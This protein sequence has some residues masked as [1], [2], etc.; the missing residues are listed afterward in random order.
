MNDISIGRPTADGKPMGRRERKKM[1]TRRRIFRAAFDLFTR[2]GF[3][4]TT[5]EEIAQR[6][7]VGKGTVFNYFPQKTAF[8][9]AAYREWVELMQEELGPIDEW[10]GPTRD[11]LSRIFGYL[12]K[13]AVEYRPLARLIIF[14]NMRQAHLRMNLDEPGGPSLGTPPDD[15]LAEEPEA[16]RLLEVMAR[17]IIRRGKARAEIRP[18]VD[19]TQAAS[20]IAVAA[21]LT[22]VR[23][24]VRGGS[25]RDI[26]LAL[27]AKMDI[28]FS[29][30]AP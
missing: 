21:F 20:L 14:E 19:D 18:E 13:K 10:D 8:L 17:E 11:Q 15:A 12:T 1:D 27:G 6:A 7:D 4:A 2:K 22:L 25:A 16:V 30:L 29:G 26:D 5:V 3:D 9:V 28:I 24:L 23:G